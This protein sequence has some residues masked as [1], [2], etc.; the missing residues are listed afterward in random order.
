MAAKIVMPK[1]GLTMEEGTILRWLRGT[2]DTVKAGEVVLEVEG[3]KTTAEVESPADGVL[4]EILAEEG[5]T[6]EVG[7]AVGTIGAEAERTATPKASERAPRQE[8]GH[9]ESHAADFGTAAAASDGVEA[10]IRAERVEPIVSPRV[11]IS[12]RARRLAEKHG[13]DW[14]ALTG[15]DAESGRIQE[16]DVRAAI[17]TRSGAAPGGKRIPFTSLRTTVARRLQQSASVAPHI[18]L[19]ADVDATEIRALRERYAERFSGE[20]VSFGS[21]FLM[22]AARSLS[23][24]LRLNATAEETATVQ[25]ETIN[26]CMAIGLEEGVVAPVIRDAGSLSLTE[27]HAENTRLV[28]AARSGTLRRDELIGGTFSVT[29]LGA[30]AVRAFTAV[31]NPPQVG[32]LSVGAIADRPAVHEDQLA[33]RPMVTVGLSVDHRAVDGVHAAAFL[34]TVQERLERPWWMIEQRGA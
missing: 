31:L 30:G 10:P 26:L 22:A 23:E 6:V 29:S 33:I 13:V 16:R 17:A 27:I 14:T 19:W 11:L 18:H 2:G 25:Y 9:A 4:L 7:R 28:A 34:Q 32:I 5:D 8:F 12:P 24:H 20:R 21:I 1:L 3:D 15:S